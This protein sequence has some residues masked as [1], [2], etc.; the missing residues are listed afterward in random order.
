MIALGLS[1]WPVMSLAAMFCMGFLRIAFQINN[2][3][4]LQ[5]S[6]PD[7]LRGRVMALYH[8]DH[9]FTPLASMAVGLLAEFLSAHLVV[10]LVGSASLALALYALSAY[11][12]VRRMEPVRG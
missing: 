11:K 10:V 7:G 6:V 5:V 8:L 12:D 4:L 9:G 1:T 3:T 2:N